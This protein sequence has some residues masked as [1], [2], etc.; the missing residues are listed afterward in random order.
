[1]SRVLRLE[2]EIEY[3]DYDATGD[4]PE[5]YP[6]PHANFFLREFARLLQKDSQNRLSDVGFAVAYVSTHPG[7][8]TFAE[9]LFPAVL[10]IPVD[11]QLKGYNR[12]TWGKS[13]AELNSLLRQAVIIARK[14]LPTLK[15]ELTEQDSRTPWLLPVKNFRSAILVDRL[16]A[17]HEALREGADVPAELRDLRRDFE[18]THPPQRIGTNRRRCFVDDA[19]IEFHPP[20]RA[21][22]AFARGNFQGHPPMCL[23]SGR[24]RLGSPY[25][26]AFHYDCSKG[27]GVL[28]A[29]FSGCHTAAVKCTGNPHINVAPNDFVR[30]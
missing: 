14:T 19:D 27:E 5:G 9:R 2:P 24:R 1:M 29:V 23:V 18:H 4:K 16:R 28:K 20:G 6:N 26:R 25:D 12:T 30:P 3:E 8:D 7:A 17:V 21:R 10:T 13:L 11:W 15:K 22:H